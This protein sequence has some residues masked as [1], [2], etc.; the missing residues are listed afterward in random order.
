M[1]VAAR[2]YAIAAIWVYY[3]LLFVWLLLY[4][5]SGDRFTIVAALNMFGLYLFAPLPVALLAAPFLHRM[6]IWV[7]GLLGLLAFAW[8]WGNLFI[9]SPPLASASSPELSVMTFNALGWADRP[10]PQIEML[11]QVDA[12]IVLLQEYNLH[13]D[14]AAQQELSDRYPYQYAQSVAGVTGLGIL[15]KLPLEPSSQELPL[16]WLG[17]PQIYAFEWSGRRVTLV[18][19]HMIPVGL[20]RPSVAREQNRYREAQAAALNDLAS[21][22]DVM[23]AAGDANTTPLSDAYRTFTTD[24]VDAWTSAGVGLGHTFPGSAIPGSSRPRIAGIPVPK[25]LA[26]I[27]YVLVSKDWNVVSART[28]PFDGVS[29]H[30]GV[31]VHLT[32]SPDRY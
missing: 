9:P 5:F 7:G 28:A 18:N 27:D 8:L 17:E 20:A 25:W 16:E 29:D 12:D 31:V 15:S 13:L 14:E 23:I 3:T 10:Q 32:L 19:F 2:R 24:L 26:R 1:I 30:R 4:R 11:R 22:T 6:E 21:R